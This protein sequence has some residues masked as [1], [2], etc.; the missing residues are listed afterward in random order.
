MST[1]LFRFDGLPKMIVLAWTILVFAGLV[2]AQLANE[3]EKKSPTP[4][5]LYVT[6]TALADA[7]QQP[8]NPGL[9]RNVGGWLHRTAKL[10]QWGGVPT[11]LHHLDKGMREESLSGWAVGAAD[12]SIFSSIFL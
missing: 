9:T 8:L 3:D 11:E 4:P 10:R 7:V 2:N 1:R 5:G 12:L 6:P